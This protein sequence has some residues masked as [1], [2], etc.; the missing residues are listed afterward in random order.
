MS[1]NQ[2]VFAV[3]YF[4]IVILDLLANGYMSAIALAMA[5]LI[6]LLYGAKIYKD[7]EA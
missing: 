5:M 6:G 4:V 3:F 7:L 2:R 1:E